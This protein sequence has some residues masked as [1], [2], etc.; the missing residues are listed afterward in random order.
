[1]P[2]LKHCVDTLKHLVLK[3]CRIP[4]PELL[5]GWR[6]NSEVHCQLL[7]NYLVKLKEYAA[8]GDLKTAKQLGPSIDQLL[9]VMETGITEE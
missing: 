6:Q 3:P 1:M 9:L 8:K 5:I 4:V 7:H 2:N